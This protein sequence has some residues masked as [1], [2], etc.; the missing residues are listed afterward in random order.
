MK[1]YE[2]KMKSIEIL[3]GSVEANSLE[4]AIEKAKNGETVG[5]FQ[6]IDSQD[7]DVFDFQEI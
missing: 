3:R 7:G 4:E 5:D 1:Q 2:F 6:V